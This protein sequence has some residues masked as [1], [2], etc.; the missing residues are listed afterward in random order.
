MGSIQLATTNT[1][2][3]LMKISPALVIVLHKTYDNINQPGSVASFTEVFDFKAGGSLGAYYISGSTRNNNNNTGSD[4]LLLAIDR[5]TG[6][7]INR[8]S[9]NKYKDGYDALV[10]NLTLRRPARI[11][12]IFTTG[13]LYT[14]KRISSRPWINAHN[15]SLGF[16]NGAH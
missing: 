6:V 10:L 11:I 8:Y 4:V 13:G 12:T 5:N 7:I 9:G 3:Y 15:S 1:K 16:T 2:A 14:N